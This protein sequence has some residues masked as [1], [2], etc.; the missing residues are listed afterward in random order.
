MSPSTPGAGWNILPP[1]TIAAENRLEHVRDCSDF[2]AGLLDRFPAWKNGL[3][4]AGLPDVS[5]LIKAIQERGL[6]DGLRRFRNREMLRIVW[7]DLNGLASLAE[8]FESLTV[9][10]EICLQ[11]ALE[12]HQRILE[13]KH[14]TPRGADGEPQ[15]MFV[16]GLGK[17]GGGELNLSS[18][19][20]VIF[21]YSSSG[22]CDGR[23][24]LSND[25]F[26]TRQA[27]AVTAP[28]ADQ[29]TV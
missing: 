29:P 5:A 28:K 25:Q 22:Q 1:E 27:R 24:S 18:D 12:E 20:D 17:F 16:I 4:E 19:I 21:C 3:D 8:T 7:R 26:F 13:E 10:A 9:L 6:D 15:R 14:G 2:A 23:R 11:S